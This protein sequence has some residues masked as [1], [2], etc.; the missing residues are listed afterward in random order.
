[1]VEAKGTVKEIMKVE[2]VIAEEAGVGNHGINLQWH[3]RWK[4]VMEVKERVIAE[5][6]EV[7]VEK[8]GQAIVGTHRINHSAF[9]QWSKQKVATILQLQG[10]SVQA[11]PDT[12]HYECRPHE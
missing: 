8:G 3:R 5:G 12:L 6:G 2:R 10:S 7:K 11:T 9:H 4:V 1:M